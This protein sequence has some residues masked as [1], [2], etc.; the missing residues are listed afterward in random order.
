[1]EALV[2]SFSV[3]IAVTTVIAGR[4]ELYESENLDETAETVFASFEAPS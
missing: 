3:K 1:L 4:E 2:F